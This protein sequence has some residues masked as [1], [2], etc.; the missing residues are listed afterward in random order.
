MATIDLRV[1]ADA[2]APGTARHA[3]DRLEGAL[4]EGVVD[5][6][7]LLVSE[8]V[9]NSVRH[10]GQGAGGWVRLMVAVSSSRV[11]VEVTDPG[12]GFEVEPPVPSIYQESGWG[13]FLVE[14][15]AQRWGVERGGGTSVWFEIDLTRQPSRG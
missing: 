4:P 15:V 7:R 9:T 5:D 6:L 14:Q 3:V 13:L 10:S 1:E 2:D 12:P 11:R 8:L